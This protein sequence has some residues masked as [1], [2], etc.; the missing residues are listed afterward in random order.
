VPGVWA[1]RV[2]LQELLTPAVLKIAQG[3]AFAKRWVR[4]HPTAA[5]ELARVPG[6]DAIEDDTALALQ[7]V[8]DAGETS[9][10]EAAEYKKRKL[11]APR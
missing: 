4:K 1:Q 5:G 3:K 8:R 2:P 10:K 9:E 7:R 11:V 6:V